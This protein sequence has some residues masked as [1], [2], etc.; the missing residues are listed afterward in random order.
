MFRK[1]WLKPLAATAVVGAPAYFIY[2]HYRPQTFDLPF[3]VKNSEGK[4]EMTT[5]RFTLL[6]LTVLE[7]RLHENA[8]SEVTTRPNGITWRYTTS[9]LASNDPIEDAHANQIVERD[10]D[11]PSAPGDYLFFAVMDGHSGTETSKLLSRI[12]IKGVATELASL[13]SKS[14]TSVPSFSLLNPFKSTFSSSPL[15]QFMD[16]DPKHVSRTIEEAFTKLDDELI[17][18]P[19]RILANS[20]D[21]EAF[22][23]KVIPDLSKHPL[24]LTAMRPAIAGKCFLVYNLRFTHR[25]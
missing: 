24:A 19:L 2:K 23:T 13:V 11:D 4:I 15:Q 12:L 25:S 3:R 10:P 18:T 16:G 6:P 14:A 21:Q 22:K 7:A 8:V 17:Q 1:V 9:N 20:M 5:K